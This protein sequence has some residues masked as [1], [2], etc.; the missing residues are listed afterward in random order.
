MGHYAEA[1][2]DDI[3]QF[4][5]N[6]VIRFVDAHPNEVFSAFA[7]DC[8]VHEEVELNLCLTTSKHLNEILHYYQ[9]GAN[10]AYYLSDAGILSLKYNT[11]DWK[12][13]CFS[14][15]NCIHDVAYDYFSVNGEEKYRYWIDLLSKVMADFMAS[16]TFA[17]IP[18]SEGFKVLVYDHEEEPEDSQIRLNAIDNNPFFLL[19]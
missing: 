18:K 6:E 10:G 16:P 9:T 17:D 12:Y 1:S 4:V 8:N 2:A 14:S 11:G 19:D 5:K 3:A 15:M 7:F 13:Q